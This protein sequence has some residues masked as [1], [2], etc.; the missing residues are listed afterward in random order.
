MSSTKGLR[1]LAEEFEWCLLIPGALFCIGL[2][3]Q[4]TTTVSIA[5]RAIFYWA[6]DQF[7]LLN[8]RYGVA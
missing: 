7:T 5:S 2:D 6:G 1:E 4:S 8:T 3:Q